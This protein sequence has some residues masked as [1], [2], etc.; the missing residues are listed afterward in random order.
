MIISLYGTYRFEII[1]LYCNIF[2]R[3]CKGTL[4]LGSRLVYY[5]VSRSK[6]LKF[7]EKRSNKFDHFCVY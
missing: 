7:I 6:F 3:F 4:V 1:T 5:I 2:P